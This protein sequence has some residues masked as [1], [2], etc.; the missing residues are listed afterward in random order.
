[1]QAQLMILQTE[2]DVEDYPLEYDT[3]PKAPV[4][5][6]RTTQILAIYPSCRQ[7]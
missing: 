6:K 3:V 1:M 2:R 4:R 5:W 7:Q